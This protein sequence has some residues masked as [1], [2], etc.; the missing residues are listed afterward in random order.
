MRPR[1]ADRTPEGLDRRRRAADPAEP[2]R[3]ARHQRSRAGDDTGEAAGLHP[4][5]LTLTFG[6]GPDAVHPRRRRPLRAR[7]PTAGARWSTCPAFAGD[8]LDPDAAVATCASRRA[9]TTHRCA[10][11]AIR[12]LT[13]IARG[14]AVI[15]WSQ[16]GFGRTAAT[17]RSKTRPQPDG[18]QGR[19][20]QPA[21][22]V[23]RTST[24]ACG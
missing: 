8:E 9:A 16:N 15:R 19:H 14:T 22:R 3:R 5:R 2:G 17:T 23:A 12:N 7:R 6:F 24:R 20:Q 21:G 18:L 13:R 1:L 4:A 11:H 10:Y